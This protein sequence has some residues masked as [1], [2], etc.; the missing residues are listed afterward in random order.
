MAEPTPRK[1]YKM[2]ITKR[3][4]E[5][6]SKMQSYVLELEAKGYRFIAGVDEAGRGP[7]AGPVVAAACILPSQEMFL[8][9]NDSKKMTVKRREFLYQEIV[10]RALAYSIIPVSSTVIDLINIRNATLQAMTEAVNNLCP[11]PDIVLTDAM[12]LKGLAFPIQALTKGDARVNSI[13]AAS[14]LAKVSRDRLMAEYDKLYPG[15]GFAKHKGYG[16][17]Q[18]YESLEKLGASP[19][20]RLS[21][22]RPEHKGQ[23]YSSDLGLKYEKAVAAHLSGQGYSIIAR[24]YSIPNLGEI[25][26]ICS[27]DDKIYFVE[28]KARANSSKEYG[29]VA[30]AITGHKIKRL[31]STAEIF[32][33]RYALTDRTAIMIA[34]LVSCD[35]QGEVERIKYCP[36]D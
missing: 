31:R 9:L 35:G 29:G 7:L 8:G 4:E 19:I 13:A 34:A 3:D 28:V 32:L 2:R 17:K 16:T 11:T 20:H 14:V 26:L 5:R 22:L 10:E 6:W 21:F 12:V 1:Q 30:E 18:H 36:I 24:R 33:E 23:S 25:D 27:K 15:Y